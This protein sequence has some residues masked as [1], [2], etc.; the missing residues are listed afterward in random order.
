MSTAFIPAFVA[1]ILLAP[2]STVRVDGDRAPIPLT[3]C[4]QESE[5]VLVGRVDKLEDG[6]AR[7]DTLTVLKGSAPKE[8]IRLPT[9]WPE[10]MSW[11]AIPVVLKEGSVLLL[12]LERADSGFRPSRKAYYRAVTFVKGETAAEV[13]ATAVFVAFLAAASVDA[14]K[15]VLAAA[16]KDESADARYLVVQE[17]AFFKSEATAP[18]LIEGIRCDDRRISEYAHCVIGLHGYREAVPQLIE[19]VKQQKSMIAARTLGE[20]KAGEAYDA[21]LEAAQLDP[22]VSN[23]FWAVQALGRL[24]DR[25]AVPF[26]VDRL[27]WDVVGLGKEGRP[28]SGFQENMFAAEALGKMKAVEAVAPLLKLLTAKCGDELRQKAIIALGDIGPAAKSALGELR[29]VAVNDKDA[30]SRS[31]A[32][33]AIKKINKE[34]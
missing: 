21:L 20:L 30:F 12:F 27:H 24:E 28:S 32:G 16:W 19:Q 34:K 15:D 23:R 7:V 17:L 2:A 26:L 31:Y 8:P 18:F 10:F 11:E 33:E 9:Q 13:R 29:Y 25:R 22:A 4:I 1:A 6:C 3:Q 5:L 14:R